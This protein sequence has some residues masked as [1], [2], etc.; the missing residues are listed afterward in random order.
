VTARKYRRRMPETT[1][2]ACPNCGYTTQ[3]TTAGQAAR[4]L[5]IHSCARWEE[6]AAVSRR[7]IERSTRS[8]PGRDCQHPR[9]AHTHG[10]S[11]AYVLDR[12]RCRPCTDAA[13]EAWRD[14][15]RQLAY[16][17]WKPYV[18]AE[19]ARQHVRALQA[20]GVGLR[21]I[22]DR[23]GVSAGVMQRLMYGRDGRGQSLRIRA[24]TADAIL[25]VTAV[26]APGARVEGC[27]A[28]RRLRALLA[29][30]WSRTALAERM[31]VT[32]SAL[33]RLVIHDGDVLASTAATVRV[34]YDRL[35]DVG[36]PDQSRKEREAVTRT[37]KDAHA[38]GWVLPQAWDDETIDDPRARPAGHVPRPVESR[39][40]DAVVAAAVDMARCGESLAGAA[41]RI[42]MRES[43]LERTLL[44]AGRPD[45]V[46]ALRVDAGERLTA[47]LAEAA[48]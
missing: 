39:R 44:R 34:L 8:G 36:P 16:G 18:D 17:R 1:Q 4:S 15:S 43:N 13:A 9:A 11:Q 48:S 14:R 47:H 7:K 12:C 46:R 22:T 19:P 3:M 26:P 42:G 30:G 37:L 33:S 2:L 28:R 31:G 45:V 24:G 41:A 10:T 40:R 25:A 38:R 27:G 35:W 29:L 21:T 23:S 20:S 6:V 32:K 5:R